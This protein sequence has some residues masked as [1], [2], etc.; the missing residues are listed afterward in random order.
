MVVAA[1]ATP[2]CKK[3]PGTGLVLLDRHSSNRT[4]TNASR[5]HGT[6]TIGEGSP[7][8][9]PY[10]SCLLGTPGRHARSQGSRPSTPSSPT[11]AR[12][13]EVSCPSCSHSHSAAQLGLEIQRDC[14]QTHS[15]ERKA[16]SRVTTPHCAP[17]VGRHSLQAGKQKPRGAWRL[18]GLIPPASAHSDG[19]KDGVCIG[20][21]IFQLW[22]HRQTCASETPIGGSH[23]CE[24]HVHPS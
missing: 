18:S 6:T 23:E 5:P 14:R 10:A 9:C 17:S 15:R 24:T 13:L 1:Q 3:S 11:G 4:F 7:G 12:R 20:K 8:S 22:G 16:F 21:C 19:D 2:P